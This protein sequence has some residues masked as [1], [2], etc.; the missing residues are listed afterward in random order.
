MNVTGSSNRGI[1]WNVA[2]RIIE[3]LLL[4]ELLGNYL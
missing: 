2:G 3:G 1:A 4:R